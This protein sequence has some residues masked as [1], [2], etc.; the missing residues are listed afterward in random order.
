M[1]EQLRE[2]A[3]DRQPLD[4]G[5]DEPA[6]PEAGPQLRAVDDDDERMAA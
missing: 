1:R 2:P 4:R 5:D 6:E 3:L